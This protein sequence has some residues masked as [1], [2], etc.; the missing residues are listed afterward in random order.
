MHD[1]EFATS[2]DPVIN[3]A[4]PAL[5]ELV[6]EGKCKFIG[7]TGYPLNVLKEAILRAPGRFDVKYLI[8][9]K[10]DFIKEYFKI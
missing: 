6:K 4:L 7:V 3:E 8:K 9:R 5:E 2:L 1:V 10:I